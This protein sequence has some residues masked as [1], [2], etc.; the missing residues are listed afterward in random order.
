MS[1]QFIIGSSGSG[2]SYYGYSKLIQE[3]RKHP[4]RSYYVIVPEQFTMQT[5]KTLVEMHPGKGILNI[6]VLSFQRLAY[7]VFQEVGGDNRKLLEDTGKSMVLQKMVQKHQK[8]LPY[9]GS[10]MKKPGYLDEVKSLISEFMQYDI[11]EPELEEML[12]RAEGQP[13]LSMKLKDVG[14]LYRAFREYLED[15]YLTGEELMD[16]LLK[17]LPFS[18]KVRGS[19]LLLDGFTGFTPIQVN[20]LR[21][22]LLLCR[23]VLVTVTM[24]AGESPAPLGKP[25]QLFYMSKKMIHTLSSLTRDLE[26]PVLLDTKRP[27]RFD[28]APALRFMEKH[29]FRYKR[30][31]YDQDQKEIRIYSAEN[32]QKEMEETARRIHALV[33]TEGMKYGEIAVI[34]GNLEEYGDLA[35][36]VFGEA[37][38]PCF[39]DQKHTVLMNPFVEYLRA[40]LEM[41]TEGFSYECVFRYLRSGM[42]SL[43]RREIDR[44]ENYVIALGIR[45]FGRWEEIWSR[46]FRGMDPGDFLSLNESRQRFA[47][48]V[49]PLAQGFMGGKK[50]VYQYCYILYQFIAGCA[51]QE[52]LK[53]QE[54]SFGEKGNRAMEK[55]YAQIYGIIMEL[56]DKMTEILGEELVTKQ[57]FR[58]LLETGLSKAKVALIPPSMDQILVGDMERT[59][60]KD[61]KALFFVGVNEGSIPK[62]ADG[63]GM[64]TELDRDFL[65]SQGMELAPGPKEQMH[66]QRFYLYLNLTKPSR[67]LSLSY[68]RSSRKG[69]AISPAYLIH[70]LMDLYQGLEE[71]FQERED[72]IQQLELPGTSLGLFLKGLNRGDA[73]REDPVFQELYSWYLRSPRYQRLVKSLVEA[74]MTR[75][76]ADVI[77]KAVAK[78]LY[79]E[80][81][82]YG[83]TRLERY[84]ACAFAHFL[85]Y[86]LRLTEREEYTFG[87]ADLGNVLHRALEEF[88]RKVDQE[89][90]DWAA[91]TPEERDRLVEECIQLVTADYGNTILK[92][93]ARNEAMIQRSKRILS[94]TVWALQQQLREGSFRPEGFEV[95]FQGGR[96]DRVDLLS[97]DGKVYVKV[98]DYKTGNTS[99]DLVALYHGLQ[100]QLMVYLDAALQVEQKKYPDQEVIPAGIF[101]YNIQDPMIGEKLDADLKTV[102]QQI[103]KE[104]RMN[105]LVQGEDHMAEK[106][107]RT[108]ISLPVSL[109]KDGSFRKN[110]SVASKE[111]FRVL[112]RYVE[113]KIGE[114]QRAILSGDAQVSPYQLGKRNA[115]AYCPYTGVCGFDGRIS[116][117]EFRR[118]KQYTDEELWKAF[119]EEAE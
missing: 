32:P 88:A 1:L 3:S 52:K 12:E 75:R 46:S 70:T 80:A 59:R 83:A 65:A 103:Q 85:Q 116:G 117:Y 91:L 4:E 110:S 63:G 20:V 17:A 78:A 25:H 6:D 101:Y 69:E 21:E 53:N 44:L 73:G 27:S 105:G 14:V 71:D 64:L 114:I 104:L 72:G 58:Q 108:L 35:E 11:R 56:L 8:D 18:E 106:M 2:K 79:G 54:V 115:C 102:D 113:K 9:L 76:P 82:P 33:R 62:S 112:G 5:Q 90:L 89:K 23:R 48:E 19:V 77:G 30:A 26:E 43:S 81:S 60:L 109:N 37:G 28:Q 118:L 10:Q 68:S 47:D 84:A 42:S 61:V 119:E 94:R 31:V 50:T 38:I 13:L 92:S 45:G 15:H 57:E 95:A 51:I 107:D 111:Q 49:R 87:A 22:L 7:R 93:S 41:V 86:G 66:M 34:T 36:Q 96:I 39:L 55:E 100:L 24:D 67:F 29:L 40:S 99:F 97:E 16:A 74:S 98:I